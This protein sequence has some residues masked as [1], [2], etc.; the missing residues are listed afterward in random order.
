MSHAAG[1]VCHGTWHDVGVHCSDIHRHV[2]V[3]NISTC[4]TMEYV[5]VGVCRYDSTACACAC[6]CACA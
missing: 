2:P 3:P 4:G 1:G 6:A 5:Y